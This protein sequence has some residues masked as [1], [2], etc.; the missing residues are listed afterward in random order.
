MSLFDDLPHVADLYGPPHR[1]TDAGG[2]DEV[3]WPNARA[4]AVPCLILTP[5]AAEAAAFAQ[6]GIHVTHVVA[7]DGDGSGVERG[8]K[9]QV[10]DT[11]AYFHV[12]GIRVQR[13]VGGIDEFTYVFCEE[14]LGQ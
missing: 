4:M 3:T 11:Q 14:Q 2:G 10:P 6:Q 5:S 7:L 13:G 9:I 12:R 1:A 8:D